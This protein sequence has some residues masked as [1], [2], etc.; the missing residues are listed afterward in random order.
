M[1]RTKTAVALA[2]L[3]GLMSQQAFADK[4]IDELRGPGLGNEWRL[5][6]NDTRKNIKA[7]DKRDDDKKYRSFKLDLIIDAPLET[8]ARAYFDIE[9][10]PRWFWEVQESRILK[11][12]SDTEFYYYVVHRAPVSQPDRDAIIHAVIE[13]YTAKKGYALFKL[14]AKPDYMPP[15][16]PLVRMNAEDMIIKWTPQPDGTTREEVEGYIDPGGKIPAW[17]INAVQRQAPYYTVM[18]LQRVVQTERFKNS[19]EP[20]PFRVRE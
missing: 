6:K 14:E 11:K 16:P 13:P 19:K 18:G 20:L 9:Y 15:R 17:A 5:I 1:T 2:A 7:W 3:I 4:D 12:V 10:Y 8:V